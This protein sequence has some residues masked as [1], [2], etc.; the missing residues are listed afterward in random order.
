MM[1]LR[2]QTRML[3][4]RQQLHCCVICIYLLKRSVTNTLILNPPKTT[5]FAIMFLPTEGLYAEVLR[6]SGE[7]ENFQHK[8]RVIIAG[9][10]TF[11]AILSSLRMGFRTLAIEKR[12]SEVWK[13]FGAVKTEFGKYG[14]ILTKVKKHLQTAS[15]TI[16]DTGVRT[17]AIERNLRKVEQLPTDETSEFLSLSGT[18]IENDLEVKDTKPN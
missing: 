1:Q 17:R 4:V 18:I 5:D 12:S 9:P 2:F 16:E 11:S 6:Q 15:D 3:K 8:Y 7:I 10:T 14:D 13:I